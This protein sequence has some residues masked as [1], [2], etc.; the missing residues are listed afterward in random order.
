MAE[1]FAGVEREVYWKR[2]R[3]SVWVTRKNRDPSTVDVCYLKTLVVSLHLSTSE[4]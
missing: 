3:N 2:L 1:V 4:K